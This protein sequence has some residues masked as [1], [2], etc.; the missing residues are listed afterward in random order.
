[1]RFVVMFYL[2]M[3]VFSLDPK[4]CVNCKH[5]RGTF[6]MDRFGKCS[7]F[8]VVNEVDDYLVTGVKK[9]NE[10][11]YNYCSIVRKYNPECGPQG[12]L[13]ERR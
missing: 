3:S 8:P 12:K 5:F 2:F 6:F 4:L 13:F 10:I 7:K 1:M 11:D 9:S